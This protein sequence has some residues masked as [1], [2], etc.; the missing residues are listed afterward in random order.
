[1]PI[2]IDIPQ[3]PT[4]IY[5]TLTFTINTRIDVWHW[6]SNFEVRKCPLRAPMNDRN[7]SDGDIPD[8]VR[9]R[10]SGQQQLTA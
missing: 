2:G 5:I 8:S 6:R 7:G 10:T 3:S 9:Q 4:N 1:M